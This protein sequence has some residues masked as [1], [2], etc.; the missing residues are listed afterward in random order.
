MTFTVH[1]PVRSGAIL[2]EAFGQDLARA[3]LEAMSI[4]GYRT[5]KLSLGEVALVLGLET[6]IAA[7]EWLGTR[8]ISLNYSGDDYKEDQAALDRA[9]GGAGGGYTFTR[10]NQGR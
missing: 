4:E 6:T 3:A 5:G 2:R 9:L 7:L 1:L 8:G 10:N